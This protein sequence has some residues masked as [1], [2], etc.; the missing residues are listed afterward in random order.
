MPSRSRCK[1]CCATT[2]GWRPSAL[3]CAP[4]SASC[5]SLLPRI[6]KNLI[7]S[8][9]LRAFEKARLRQIQVEA[10]EAK[11]LH[12]PSHI[13]K[14][15]SELKDH[16]W[17]E[18]PPKSLIQ[19]LTDAFAELRGEQA[20]SARADIEARLIE[21]LAAGDAAS[22]RIVRDEWNALAEKAPLD[23]AD[24]TRERVGE[25]LRWLDDLDRR[26]ISDKALE[27][28][29]NVLANA[30]N[31]P[32]AIS[33]AELE[34]LE[35][36]VLR[37]GR[38]IPE[39]IQRKYAARFRAA[40]SARKR[41]SRIIAALAAAV[42]L[43]SGSLAFYVVRSSFR[44][45]DAEQAAAEINT[46]LQKGDVEQAEAFLANLEKADASLL[47][48]PAL[49]Q[50]RRRCRAARDLE[51]E[52]AQNFAEAMEEARGAP[53][54]DAE[55]KALATARELARL[56]SEKLAV[57]EL[58]QKRRASRK[59]SRDKLESGFRPRLEAIGRSAERIGKRLDLGNLEYDR[60][61]EELDGSRRELDELLPQVASSGSELKQLGS[62]VR[63][64]LDA[65]SNRFDRLR[66]ESLRTS[67]ITDA[68][69]FNVAARDGDLGLFTTRL[70]AFVKAYP[71]EPCSKAFQAALL[72]RPLW[73]AV[74]AWN[75]LIE[76]WKKRG[77]AL[78]P[79]EAEIR[80]KACAQFLQEYPGFPEAKDVERY[81][82]FLEAIVRRGS[83]AKSPLAALQA[84]FS[85]SLVAGLSMVVVKNGLHSPKRYYARSIPA[86]R[87]GVLQLRYLAARGDRERTEVIPA[88]EIISKD[89]APQSKLA[90]RAK[91][92]LADRSLVEK[93]DTLTVDLLRSIS[94]DTEVD[95]IVQV[96]LLKSVVKAA[97]EGSEVIRAS[98]EGMKHQLDQAKI[99]LD[100]DW[101]DPDVGPL[102]EDKKQALK[103]VESLRVKV[104][105]E[106][107]LRTN[108]DRLERIVLR[109]RRTV[110]WLVRVGDRYEVKTGVALP[111]DGDLWIVAPS[112]EKRGEW[113]KVGTIAGGKPAILSHDPSALAGG[114]PVF[115]I[116]PS[117]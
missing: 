101:T 26:A 66:G 10:S 47:N 5:A 45:R 105:T 27:A 97:G 15:L 96:I 110:G 1:T 77:A 65:V 14:L 73:D 68:V 60:I 103:L 115:M 23:P 85:N 114:R 56:D 93:W 4:A 31:H 108:R 107:Q 69:A 43:V 11:R 19:G 2:G 20:R 39:K 38:G 71:A 40:S 92:L 12:D 84:L 67:E 111:G 36:E 50:V 81:R 72:E 64:Q 109:A 86:E 79:T 18:P 102:A 24:P 75:L 52:R 57:D 54:G 83:G 95:P 63:E 76:G 33:A 90:A 112:S 44:E 28:D 99:D 49:A 3:P 25:A 100:L 17:L 78:N 116:V 62:D 104:P 98:L 94:S 117:S 30:L 113:K 53:L 16:T 22:G 91:E 70:S 51:T 87:N 37:H 8:E 74:A 42:I 61:E 7:W 35:R 106:S 29:L 58:V 6:S 32:A 21:S 59:D 80:A 41:R 46:F 13:G 89:L 34:R 82:A 88:K 55:P 48:D 9:D